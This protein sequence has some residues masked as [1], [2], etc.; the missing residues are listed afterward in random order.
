MAKIKTAI[1]DFRPDPRLVD[2]RGPTPERAKKLRPSPINIAV[3]DGRLTREHGIAAEKFYVHWFRAGIERG[4]GSPDLLHV[5]G[6]DRLPF[7]EK[8]QF[9]QKQLKAALVAVEKGAGSISRGTLISAV[10]HE[11]PFVEIGAVF[12][13]KNRN[14]AVRIAMQFLRPALDILCKEWGVT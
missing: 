14:T 12:G 2:E 1:E 6:G 9:H 3:A 4:C 7:T 8:Q 13:H 5:F 10:I 11:K